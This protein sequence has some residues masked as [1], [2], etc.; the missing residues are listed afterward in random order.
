M[1]WQRWLA[2]TVVLVLIPGALGH[3]APDKR[4]RIATLFDYPPYGFYKESEALRYAEV[5]VPP[6]SDTAGFQGYSWDI[7]RESFHSQGYTIE[8]V[9][10]HWARAMASVKEGRVDLLYPAGMNTERLAYFSYSRSPINDAAF[11]VYIN[12]ETEID[13]QGL[14][15]LDGMTIGMVRG[16]NFGDAWA[17]QEG[18]SKYPLDSIEQGF[19]MLERQRLDGFAGYETNWDYVLKE[20]GLQDRFDKLPEFGSSK[21]YVVGLRDNPSTEQL[22]R[23]FDT[24]FDHIRES[25]EYRR[26]TERWR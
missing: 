20:M 4:V 11:R 19:R 9:V 18:F 25:G 6:G 23:D 1:A 3:T 8:L 7:L 16:Y 2:L 5:V 13:W 22:L 15:S 14:S 12:P 24:G 26:I 17:E 10:T 21:E